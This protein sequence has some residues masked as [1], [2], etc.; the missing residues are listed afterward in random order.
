MGT[1]HRHW[2]IVR[3]T[4]LILGLAL[5]CS[6]GAEKPAADEKSRSRE[7]PPLEFTLTLDGRPV[8]IRTDQPVRV[9]VGDRE[10]EARLTPKPERLLRVPGLSFRYPAGH[11][12]EVER[13]DASAQ[14]TLDGNHNVI[15][16]SRVARKVDPAE[17]ARNTVDRLARQFGRKNVTTSASEMRLGGR[18]YA[19]THLKLTT[20]SG[21]LTYDVCAFNAGDDA[22]FLL[23]VQD[24]P[25]PD[26]SPSDETRR[27]LGL[28]DQ[29]LKFEE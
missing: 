15:I 20:K 23:M 28:L 17:I 9:K 12:F 24:S 27:V 4:A 19:A 10:V 25:G 21:P 18:A 13:T 6:A 5:A 1:R 16:L 2:V 7:E 26:G 3:R 22:T 14:W 11:G 29:T 8:D